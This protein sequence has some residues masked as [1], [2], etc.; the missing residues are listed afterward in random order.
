MQN[1][2][3]IIR[4]DRDGNIK[5]IRTDKIIGRD[6]EAIREL[7]KDVEELDKKLASAFKKLYE[8]YEKSKGAYGVRPPDYQEKEQAQKI[9][10]LTDVVSKLVDKVER[11]ENAKRDREE[12]GIKK[13]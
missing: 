13:L 12:G 4:I 10:L 8:D 1:N 5:N 9:D 3:A 2:E 6:L 11:M 7:E